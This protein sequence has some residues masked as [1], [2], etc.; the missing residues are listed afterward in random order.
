MTIATREKRCAF[1]KLV[2]ASPGKGPLRAFPIAF[3]NILTCS[4]VYFVVT[5]RFAMEG[6]NE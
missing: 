2:A 1:A 6:F 4:L 3:S 5:V